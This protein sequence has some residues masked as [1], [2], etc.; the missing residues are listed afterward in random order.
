MLSS[1]RFCEKVTIYLEKLTRCSMSSS[2]PVRAVSATGQA[3]A[4]TRS[5][6]RSRVTPLIDCVY[7][8]EVWKLAECNWNLIWRCDEI[9]LIDKISTVITNTFFAAC[10]CNLGLEVLQELVDSQY[11]C[12]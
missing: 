8:V 5:E 9:C 7:F 12:V 3:P 10:P 6:I 4:P 2:L 1:E 11:G